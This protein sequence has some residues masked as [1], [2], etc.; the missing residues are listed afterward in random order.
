[1]EGRKVRSRRTY[2][3][4]AWISLLASLWVPAVVVRSV[5]FSNSIQPET[6]IESRPTIQ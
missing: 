5:D 6:Q 1:M 3:G 2:V 4:F